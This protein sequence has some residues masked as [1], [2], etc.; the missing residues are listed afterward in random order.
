M[1]YE[2][3]IARVRIFLHLTAKSATE[4][5]RLVLVRGKGEIAV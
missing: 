4:T 5:N 2:N 3:T 1:M